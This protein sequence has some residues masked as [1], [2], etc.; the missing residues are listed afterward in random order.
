MALYIDNV[1]YRAMFGTT[2][3]YFRYLVL[4]KLAQPVVIVDEENSDILQITPD[5][6]VEQY[7]LFVDDKPTAFVDLE[8]NLTMIVS[9]T[10]DGQL[11]YIEKGADWATWCNSED[12]IFGYYIADNSAV[13]L[14]GTAVGDSEDS[15]YYIAYNN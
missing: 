15:I 4:Q 7:I 11:Y 12:N 9:F 6:N 2:Q 1:K 10:L 5:E 13:A 3:Y 14:S 8:G